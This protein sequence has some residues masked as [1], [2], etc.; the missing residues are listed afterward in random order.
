MRAATDLQL[1]VFVIPQI[2]G[3]RRDSHGARGVLESLVKTKKYAIPLTL[4]PP[5]V[6]VGLAAGY[7]VTGRFNPQRYA[8]TTYDPQDLER[9]ARR[10]TEH[11]W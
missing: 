1:S 5:W 10:A 3:S 4:A 8:T 2:P 9:D 11:H 7:V 6:P